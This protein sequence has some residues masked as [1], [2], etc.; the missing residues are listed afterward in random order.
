MTIRQEVIQRLLL[1]KLILAPSLSA[2]CAEPDAH[3]VATHVL[4]S[5]DAADLVFAAIAD[6]Q[7]KLAKKG[8]K[9]S[10]SMMESLDLVE[11]SADFHKPVTFFSQL[12]ETRNGLKHKGILPNTR[13]WGQVGRETYEK[14]S[15]L[16][17]NCIELPLDEIDE[18]AL[19]RDEE[20]RNYL[21]AAKKAIENHENK[22][23]LEEIARALRTQLDQVR[24]SFTIEVGEA[25]AEDAIK[26]S[27]FGVDANDFLRL[28]EFL[29]ETRSLGNGFNIIWKQSRFGHPC[30]WRKD[31]AQF[32]LRAFLQIALRI[33]DAKWIPSA[34]ELYQ[35]YKYKVTAKE[36]NVE[37]WVEGR[38]YG[39][40]LVTKIAVGRLQKGESKTFPPIRQ[41]LVTD[42]YD[43]IEKQSLKIV[44]LQ[45]DSYIPI[46][47]PQQQFVLFDKV[48][49]T[50]VRNDFM[51]EQFPDLIE[52]P[53][54]SDD[55]KEQ[56]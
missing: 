56:S 39:S 7:G 34:I 30:N 15:E 41:P 54:R 49:I 52:I 45:E 22:K 32:C 19:L 8:A 43:E 1:A 55:Q 51:R 11:C 21:A 12:N 2:P 5:H 47:G 31:T 23:G 20:V 37:I 50:C 36:D 3:T 42:W 53:W 16:C 40:D 44:N 6:Q 35:L 33:Q 24:F 27:G 38:E 13:Q 4:T 46:S 9:Q 10:P 25:K 28:Q 17:H 48:T 29:P 14:L 26:L 18:S